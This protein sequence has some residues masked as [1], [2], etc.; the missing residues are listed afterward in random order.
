MS[1]F[2]GVSFIVEIKHSATM[3][4]CCSEVSSFC[5]LTNSNIRGY[6]LVVAKV[7]IFYIFKCKCKVLVGTISVMPTHSD[8]CPLNIPKVAVGF[9]TTRRRQQ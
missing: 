1:L 7:N 3:A 2:V 8:A 9:L 5:L 4:H 6:I